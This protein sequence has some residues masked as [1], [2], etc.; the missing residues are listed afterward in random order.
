MLFPNGSTHPESPMPLNAGSIHTQGNNFLH[1]VQSSVDPR[2]GQFNLA[3]TLALG[4]ANALAGPS[5]AFTL[6]YNIL[7]AQQDQG[8]GLGW[9]LLYTQLTRQQNVWTLRLSSGEQ[10]AVDLANSQLRPGGTL[11]FLD[12]KL[13]AMQVTILQ[14]EGSSGELT[15]RLRHKTGELEFLR[16][17]GGT[18]NVYVLHELRSPEGHRL[19]F[20]WLS[21]AEV[22]HLMAVRDEQRVL[23][24]YD[25]LQRTLTLEP[26]TA[27]AAVY[28][29]VLANGEMARLLLPE[30][31][32][33]FVF[34][35]ANQAVGDQYLRVPVEI[36]GPLGAMDTIN[37]SQTL[38]SSHRLPAK[39]PI[40]FMPRVTSWLH[41]DGLS[42]DA[43]LRRYT[44]V[45]SRNY[46]GGDTPQGFEWETG[47]DSLYRLM[48]RYE[49]QCIET[50]VSG[51]PALLHWLQVGE[52]IGMSVSQIDAHA[53]L[54]GLI[55][56]DVVVPVTTITRTWD[57]HHL[58]IT[59]VTLTGLCQTTRE[60]TYGVD[61]TRAWQDQPAQC[62]LPHAIKT[63]Y[64]HTGTRRACSEET[65]YDYDAFGNTLKTVLP[66]GVEEVYAYYP[67]SGDTQGCPKDD[68]GMVRWLKQKIIT[69]VPGSPG[70]APILCT[71]YEYESLPSLIAGDPAHVV[72][73][74]EELIDSATGQVLERT[75]QSYERSD[76]VH[77]GRQKEA[78]TTLNGKTTTS[79]FEHSIVS[80]PG[81]SALLCTRT[82]VKGFENSTEAS[83]TREDSRSLLTGLTHCEVSAAG[84]RTRFA[85]DALGRVTRTV[86]A[87]GSVY[88]AVR[89]C[90]YHLDDDFVAQHAP[91]LDGDVAV[92]IGL[93]ETDA[94][95]QRKR[96]WLDGSS[97]P[98]RIQLEDLD[99]RPGVFLE[100]LKVSHDVWGREV[101]RVDLDWSIDGNLL[102]SATSRTAYD[103]WGQPYC[104]TD[105]SGVMTY[106]VYDPT[107]RCAE[108][109]Q[110]SPAG[111][112]LGKQV[113]T[114]NVAGS[115]VQSMLFD[116]QAQAVHT[117][118]YLRD[119]LD[120]MIEQR[121]TPR[122]GPTQVTQFDY[123]HYGRLT[124]RHQLFTEDEQPLIRTV[125]WEY[126]AHSDGDHP[127]SV[128]VLAIKHGSVQ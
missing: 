21:A 76:L 98:V 14:D 20:D 41:S 8:F 17:P 46:L 36:S 102:S 44:W 87:E 105:A 55:A 66:T 121:I 24:R 33:P 90:T 107:R 119:G 127:E 13:K 45:G 94:T 112:V 111:T 95:G 106:T 75:S 71:R 77:Y 56:Q 126:A 35:Y 118:E 3:I 51:A 47:R 49:Y 7:N 96:S 74:L 63:T 120:R 16:R 48:T 34:R 42:T 40:A 117:T 101:E 68:S 62:Q 32:N 61:Y 104:Q 54:D 59:E 50:Q 22:L 29:F 125:C 15:I 6:A 57:R 91:R 100:V 128:S 11:A 82:V 39:A 53:L 114:L 73:C 4:Q 85:Y 108:R 25:R 99:N 116:D 58:L 18:G 86:I 30:I 10:F 43:L 60:T 26:D 65:T 72:I 81:E 1:A 67:A 79:L 52:R 5:W 70:N 9:S 123:D 78:V 2:T 37:W 84:T 97:R 113:T 28:R 109:W 12:Y 19:H 64:T 38:E 124:A 93:E 88:Q 122:D 69:P 89:T 115:A 27:Q 31:T 83:S 92:R 110:Q 80:N 103:D 23:A